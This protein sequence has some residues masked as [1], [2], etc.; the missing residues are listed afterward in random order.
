MVSALLMTQENNYTGYLRVAIMHVK[1]C[2]DVV[3][4]T[5]R[6]CQWY[7]RF[8]VSSSIKKLIVKQRTMLIYIYADIKIKLN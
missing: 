4:C 1:S 8:C 5:L 3:N 6:Q 2:K 7:Q